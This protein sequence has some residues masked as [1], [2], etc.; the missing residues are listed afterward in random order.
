MADGFDQLGEQSAIAVTSE[1]HRVRRVAER[2][3]LGESEQRVSHLT[4]GL[5]RR[6]FAREDEAARLT[7]GAKPGDEGFVL[8]LIGHAIQR[9]EREAGGLRTIVQGATP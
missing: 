7:M 2:L 6:N 8:A 4:V 9:V 1:K 5:Q 3:G